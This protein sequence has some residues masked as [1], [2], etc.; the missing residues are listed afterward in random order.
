MGGIKSIKLN[1][2]AKDIWFWCINRNKWISADYVPGKFNVA[3]V[4][5]RNFN[6]N[7]EWM[8]EVIV[9]NQLTKILGS[10]DLDDK[11]IRF[12]RT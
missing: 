7:T 11:D 6:D 4:E 10:P 9:F 2:I 3:D 1:E 8:L 5:S 12:T